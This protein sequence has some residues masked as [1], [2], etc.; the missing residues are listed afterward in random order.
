MSPPIG[1]Q[2]RPVATPG[3]LGALGDLG[4]EALGPEELAHLL[5]ACTTT[6]SVRP[7]V[8]GARDLAADAA[9]LALEVPEPGLARVGADDRARCAS[10]V[11]REVARR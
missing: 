10:S 9:D 1:V 8:I 2:A 11:K 5:G 7:S 3:S 4:E 6:G